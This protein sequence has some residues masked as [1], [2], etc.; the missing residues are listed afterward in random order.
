MR[1]VPG[2]SESHGWRTA[3]LSPTADLLKGSEDTIPAKGP[4]GSGLWGHDERTFGCPLCKGPGV[5]HPTV[6]G[7]MS[8]KGKSMDGEPLFLIPRELVKDR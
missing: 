2:G 3:R 8:G 7:W 1:G 5:P 6:E 4:L